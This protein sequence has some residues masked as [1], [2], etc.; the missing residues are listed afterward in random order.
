MIL[1]CVSFFLYHNKGLYNVAIII[2]I[3]IIII[4]ISIIIIIR[5]NT[6]IIIIRIILIVNNQ[7]LSLCQVN[8]FHSCDIDR[9][10]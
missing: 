8:I 2:I 1:L 3:I 5:I 6:I 7:F 10:T 4:R 9:L